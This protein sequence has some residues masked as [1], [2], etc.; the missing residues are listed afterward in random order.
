MIVRTVRTVKWHPLN[1]LQTDDGP[2]CASAHR[3]QAQPLVDSGLCSNSGCGVRGPG[4]S[5]LTSLLHCGGRCDL[6]GYQIDQ[7]TDANR[8]G[9]VTVHSGC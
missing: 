1:G 2:G 9:D 8:F 7:P 5:I 6:F 3:Q 4:C